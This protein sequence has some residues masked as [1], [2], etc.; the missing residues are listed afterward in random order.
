MTGDI[1]NIENLFYDG[2]KNGMSVDL[3]NIYYK[4]Y[5]EFYKL[6]NGITFVHYNYRKITSAR[7]PG[8]ALHVIKHIKN[9]NKNLDS[10]DPKSYGYFYSPKDKEKKIDEVLTTL[11]H[12]QG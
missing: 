7:H 8:N 1:N 11:W 2:F 3:L 9:L 12:A 5:M 6:K 4:K 10:F